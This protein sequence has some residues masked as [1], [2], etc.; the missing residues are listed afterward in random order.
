MRQNYKKYCG[1]SPQSKSHL[2]WT[3]LDIQVFQASL[4]GLAFSC[5]LPVVTFN[6][7]AIKLSSPVCIVGWVWSAFGFDVLHR[8]REI[9][10]RQLLK[11]PAC[12][13]GL[14]PEGIWNAV[15]FRIADRIQHRGRKNC[16]L[17][18]DPNIVP[19]VAGNRRKGTHLSICSKPRRVVW[20]S[21]VSCSPK[22]RN[23]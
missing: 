5:S 16:E 13:C 20:V 15:Q 14:Q 23:G 2:G 3:H 4:R 6:I 21:A 7:A 11:Q 9:Q 8:G 10:A 22:F 19:R 17:R 12:L 1:D 18:F